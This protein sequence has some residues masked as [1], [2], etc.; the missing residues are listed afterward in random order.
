MLVG[1]QSDSGL[2][3]LGPMLRGAEGSSHLERASSF[4]EA[5]FEL[6][7]VPLARLPDPGPDSQPQQKRDE[8]L[9]ALAPQDSGPTPSPV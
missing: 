4:A 2:R 5:Q 9:S 7:T 8:L 6:K 1:I 3:A